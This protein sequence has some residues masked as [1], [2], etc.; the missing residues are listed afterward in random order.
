MGK[1]RTL[2]IT[3][4]PTACIRGDKNT[5]PRACYFVE[6]CD[7]LSSFTEVI[8]RSARRAWWDRTLWL[9]FASPA[10]SHIP[11]N[12]WLVPRTLC[13][14]RNLAIHSTWLMNWD[15]L[16]NIDAWKGAGTSWG[17]ALSLGAP[18]DIQGG[19]PIG[20]VSICGSITG[21]TWNWLILSYQMRSFLTATGK[22]K[23]PCFTSRAAINHHK[24]TYEQQDLP[25]TET[26]HLL[27][28]LVKHLLLIPNH[29]KRGEKGWKSLQDPAPP[30]SSALNHSAHFSLE[31]LSGAHTGINFSLS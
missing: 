29:V 19:F 3:R 24:W 20:N 1:K 8:F 6:G 13:C 25:S 5:R 4:K 26:P 9:P 21:E 10:L 18:T 15:Q 2:K 30:S 16:K 11:T 17:L 14:P 7:L 31:R 22:A 12:M 23:C 27:P 28:V